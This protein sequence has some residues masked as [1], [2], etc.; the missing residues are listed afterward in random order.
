MKKTKGTLP[1]IGI[2]L[3][4]SLAVTFFV[5]PR[6][7]YPL[8]YVSEITK[9]SEE[10]GIDPFLVLSIIKVESKFTTTAQSSEGACGLMQIMPETGEWIAKTILIE[11]YVI[12]DLFD[13]K[14][15]IRMGTWYMKYLLDYY[16]DDLCLAVAAYNGGM[17]NVSDWLEKGIWSGK[18]EDYMDI[19]FKETSKYVRS[20]DATYSMYKKIYRSKW[21]QG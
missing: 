21:P 8:K 11:K 2:I 4:M 9:Y 7:M 16:N 14:S 15:N 5:V 18:L 6:R 20:V 1:I 13:S 3:I 10:Y 19:P 12:E 17:G